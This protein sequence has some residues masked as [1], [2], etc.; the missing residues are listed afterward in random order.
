M[1]NLRLFIA[2]YLLL[3]ATIAEGE[4][5]FKWV[6]E[7]GVTH[8]S[9]G[10]PPS[11]NAQQ[12]KTQPAPAASESG[13]PQTSIREWEANENVKKYKQRRDQ[14]EEAENKLKAEKARRCAIAKDRLNLFQKE[15][16]LYRYNDKGE[17]EY[18]SDNDRAAEIKS[19]KEE[20]DDNC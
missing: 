6:D 7:Q 16:R 13:S 11:K 20:V 1:D 10:T 4:T 17:K 19:L 8:Y 9:A 3:L 14:Q 2:I 18:W 12:L 15:E 5:I